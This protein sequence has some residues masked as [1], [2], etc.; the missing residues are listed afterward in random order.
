M[1]CHWRDHNQNRISTR[2]HV[3]SNENDDI[4]FRS[5][6]FFSNRVSDICN[7]HRWLYSFKNAMMSFNTIFLLNS[8]SLTFL[9]LFFRIN[10]EFNIILNLNGSWKH[11]SKQMFVI[12]LFSCLLVKLHRLRLFTVPT[13]TMI[14]ILTYLQQLTF[15]WNA[16]D[17]LSLIGK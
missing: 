7:Y 14:F 8:V 1:S 5:I 9:L 15:I 13:L 10:F 12:F 17:I 4:L 6:F 16:W 3:N 11:I 2:V